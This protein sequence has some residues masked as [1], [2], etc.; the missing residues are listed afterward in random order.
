M[1]NNKNG[2]S[3]SY[4]QFL[5]R[6]DRLDAYNQ[7]ATEL[8]SG[9]DYSSSVKNPDGTYTKVVDD[10][11]EF[12][13]TNAFNKFNASAKQNTNPFANAS[14]L[15]AQNAQDELDNLNVG[16]SARMAREAANARDAIIEG[17]GN[18]QEDLATNIDGPQTI[19]PVAGPPMSNGTGSSRP[20]FEKGVSMDIKKVNE[21]AS[22][23]E[24]L[25]NK[26]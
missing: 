18:T 5:G 8:P 10:S 2:A 6:N 15:R 4:E 9:G 17:K 20:N 13:A 12:R 26:K 22:M 19:L 14:A 16:N 23:S 3:E 11:V 24:V 7:R 1:K 25:F 21:G